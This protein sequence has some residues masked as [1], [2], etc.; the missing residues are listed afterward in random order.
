[1]T[2]NYQAPL[3]SI[4]CNC[5]RPF[6]S[7]IKSVEQY[8]NSLKLKIPPVFNIREICQEQNSKVYQRDHRHFR[9]I[10]KNTITSLRNEVWKVK[11]KASRSSS[12]ISK[13]GVFVNKCS[14]LKSEKLPNY[15]KNNQPSLPNDSSYSESK[16]TGSS[17]GNQE[18]KL[19][20]QKP[21]K[22]PFEK[23]SSEKGGKDVVKPCKVCKPLREE[24]TKSKIL[25]VSEK[26][27]KIRAQTTNINSNSLFDF[28]LLEFSQMDI[29]GS[30]YLLKEIDNIKAE[31][32]KMQ[33]KNSKMTMPD[34]VK[35]ISDIKSKIKAAQST[36]ILENRTARPLTARVKTPTKSP[37]IRP[38]RQLASNTVT[39]SPSSKFNSNKTSNTTNNSYMRATVCSLKKQ[40]Q[41]CGLKKMV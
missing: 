17:E 28:K 27:K 9:E 10:P 19:P 22:S 36:V 13:K 38:S 20:N 5:K 8:S 6:S 24:P 35:L 39:E 7:H 4:D 15:S 21:T 29:D 2:V 25:S 37:L 3:N 12:S 26:S 14:N 40:N 23:S 41:F 32:T 30:A 34:A 18:R 11:R 33:D 31:I 16:N 1:M